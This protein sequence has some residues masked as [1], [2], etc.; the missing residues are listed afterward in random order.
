MLEQL[1]ERAKYWNATA[2]ERTEHY[3][4]DDYLAMPFEGLV[5]AISI[6][7]PTE[8]VF[9]WLCQIKVAP[10]SYDWIDNLGRRSPRKLTPG[11]EQLA[12]GQRFQVFKI[13][14]FEWHRHISGRGVPQA[15]RIFGPIAVTYAVSPQG[16]NISRLVVKLDVGRGYTGLPSRLYRVLMAWGDLVM[17]RKQLLTLKALAENQANSVKVSSGKY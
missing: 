4:C 13:S 10:Y 1:A 17:M 3:P 14:D 7:A 12:A 5:R 2:T 6:N 16:E 8:T 15:E 11:A 9:R